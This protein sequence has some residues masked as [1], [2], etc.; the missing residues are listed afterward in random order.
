MS[1]GVYAQLAPE[2][3]V[4]PTNLRKDVYDK[5]WAFDIRF[6]V[7]TASGYLVLRATEPIAATPVDGTAYTKGQQL[8]N[9]KVFA[10]GGSSFVRI[11]EAWAGTDY[12][13]AV[14]AYNITGSNTSTINYLPTPLTGTLRSKDNERGGYYS[15]IDFSSSSL[16]INLKDLINPHTMVAYGDFVNTLVKEFHERDTSNNQKVV[17]CQYSNEY[18]VYSGNFG[19]GTYNYS[20][21]HRMP[22]SWIN[23]SGITRSQFEG[24]PEGCDLHALELSNNDVNFQRSNHPLGDNV[25]TTTYTY[26]EFTLGKDNR[27]KTVANISALRHGDAARA[28]LY[29]MLCYNGKYGKN[30]GL[31]NLLS[32]SDNQELS[33][34]VE[35]HLADPPDGF[36]KA[37][38]EYVFSK[39]GN[40]NPLIDY[41]ELIHCIDFSNMTLKGDCS[42]YV[43][44]GEP[45]TIT[46]F[47]LYPQPATNWLNLSF[48]SPAEEKATLYIF[49]LSGK[50]LSQD[51]VIVAAG[52]QTLGINTA[53]LIPGYYVFSLQ[54]Q[55]ISGRGQFGVVK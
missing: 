16:L 13:F 34:L 3:T 47:A 32:D 33:E 7:S 11:R 21:E 12:Y 55:Q 14:Y 51:E 48:T 22:F 45:K 43:G 2:P 38:H 35:W 37:R 41:P 52:H 10:A 23:F 44:I 30:W 29:M 42:Q 28:K 31:S 5:P 18:L 46:N 20:R 24:M 26:L 9:A 49:D 15:G 1:M 39:Q 54:G 4:A 19:L 8:G 40:R 36:E 53:E 6:N 50:L 17:N 25:V 27:N